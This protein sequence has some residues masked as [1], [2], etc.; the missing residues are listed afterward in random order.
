MPPVRDAPRIREHARLPLILGQAAREPDRA[1]PRAREREPRRDRGVLDDIAA[2]AAREPP[3]P[4]PGDAK[5]GDQV[6][7]RI[8][9]TSAAP[10]RVIFSLPYSIMRPVVVER[11][12]VEKVFERLGPERLA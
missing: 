1:V 12:S 10:V 2:R 7:E 5:R 9:A 8:P 11:V 4:Y 3:P 6:L